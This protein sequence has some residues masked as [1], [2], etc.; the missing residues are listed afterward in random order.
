MPKHIAITTNGILRYSQKSKCSLEE[1]WK[2]SFEIILDLIRFQIDKNIPVVTFH[3]V[4][5]GL[6][7]NEIF[8]E[9][10]T[11]I[12]N[13]FNQLKKDHLITGSKVK[14]SVIGK[15][16]DLPGELVENIKDLTR[17]TKDYD[18]F[19]VN[20]CVNYDGREEIIDAMK[21]MAMKVRNGSIDPSSISLEDIKEHLY[22]SY[23]IPPDL[24]IVNGGLQST[25]GFLLWDS[26]NAKMYFTDKLWPDFK[27]DD[28]A[29]IIN[30][31]C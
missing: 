18:S 31:L 5:M 10:S 3:L 24:M 26:V 7:K 11:F 13:F 9:I 21:V 23:F 8:P 15:W 25:K 30:K 2:K 14:V 28:L 4:P 22:S 27:K 16:Y 20:F 29:K 19:F 6:V 17:E 1:S 12:S